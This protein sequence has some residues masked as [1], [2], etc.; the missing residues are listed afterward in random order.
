MHRCRTVHTHKEQSEK[1]DRTQHTNSEPYLQEEGL[2]Y[3]GAGFG[4][5]TIQN[6][7][8]K[9]ENEAVVGEHDSSLR[10]QRVALQRQDVCL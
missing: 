1:E 7:H 3:I 6:T 10:N 2:L 8:L 9:Q 5:V 4:P